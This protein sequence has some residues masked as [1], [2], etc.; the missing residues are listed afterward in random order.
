MSP[1]RTTQQQPQLGCVCTTWTSATPTSASSGMFT[2]FSVG[3][4]FSLWVHVPL[5]MFALAW[6]EKFLCPFFSSSGLSLKM[7]KWE[8][9]KWE[10]ARMT[11]WWWENVNEI[12]AILIMMVRRYKGNIYNQKI[13]QW[14][15]FKIPESQVSGM[16]AVSVKVVPSTLCGTL[17]G[18]HSEQRDSETWNKK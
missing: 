2:F 11:Q 3:V 5:L 4:F 1:L 16:D 17:T 15:H 18:Q 12:F 7:L 6:S 13:N 14:D 10:H 8:D 9:Q